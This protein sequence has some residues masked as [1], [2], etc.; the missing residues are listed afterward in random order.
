[1][2][3][4]V[5]VEGAVAWARGAAAGEL[6]AVRR[7]NRGIDVDEEQL[8]AVMLAVRQLRYELDPD[9][10]DT[11]YPKVTVLSGPIRRV[12]SRRVWILGICVHEDRC[13][14]GALVS[15]LLK[16]IK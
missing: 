8:R 11:P 1:V 5:D 6:W 13:L 12:F 10:P 7:R 3:A 9:D 14:R 15:F 16:R 2:S 4:Q